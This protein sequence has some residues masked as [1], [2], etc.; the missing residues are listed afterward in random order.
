[1]SQA[2]RQLD[3]HATSNV[4]QAVTPMAIRMAVTVVATVPIIVVYPFLQKYFVG[5]MTVGSVKD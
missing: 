4:T 2:Q 5:G 1:M 3:T